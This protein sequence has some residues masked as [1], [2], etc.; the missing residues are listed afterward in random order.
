M[1]MLTDFQDAFGHALRDA[2]DGLDDGNAHEIIERYD[3]YIAMSS[4]ASVYL[5]EP[6]GSY[7]EALDRASG[8]VLDIGCGAGRAALYLQ[9][10]G[11]DVVAIDISPLAVEVARERGVANASVLSIRDI[12]EDELGQ[13][14]SIV[15]MGNNFGLFGTH[16]RAGRLL[17]RF[18]RM[19]SEHAVLI[20]ESRDPYR[21]TDDFHRAYHEQNRLRGRMA[22]QLRIRS[23]YKS[24]R[25]P[26]FDYLFVSESEMAE[27]VAGTG[28]KIR[29]VIGSGNVVYSVVLEKHR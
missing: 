2:L 10:K 8:R 4:P 1:K 28:W 22:G 29:E 25:T 12:S 13:F 18:A 20:T 23:R 26:W 24:Y 9:N 17:R 19:T 15:M 14:D 27:I 7:H 21:T 3:G 6:A 5:K 16:G 11:L